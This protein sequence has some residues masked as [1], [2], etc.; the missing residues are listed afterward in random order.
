VRKVSRN[1]AVV[2]LVGGPLFVLQPALA[3]AVGADASGQE[4]GQAPQLAEELL[5]ARLVHR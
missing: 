1:R 3:R 5:S 4:G 2:V